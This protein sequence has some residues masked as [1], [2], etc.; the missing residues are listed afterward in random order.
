MSML[1]RYISSPKLRQIDRVEVAST[2]AEAWEAVRHLDAYRFWFVRGLFAL[3]ALPERMLSTITGGPPPLDYHGTLDDLRRPESEFQ[4]LEEQPPRG[5]VAGA[6]GTFWTPKIEWRE[7]EPATFASFDEPGYGKVAWAI[8]VAPREGGGSW[9]SFEVRVTTTDAAS[10]VAFRRYWH[11]IGLFSHA[12]RRAILGLFESELGTAPPISQRT[13]P[14]DAILAH[15]KTVRDHSIRIEA[16]PSAVWPWLVQMGCNR[17]GWY[18]IDR[19][20]NGGRPSADRIH[21]E[22]QTL[23]VGDLLDATPGGEGAFGVL[24][25]D[26]GHALVLG[27]PSLRTCGPIA[28]PEPN[29]RSTWA[30]VLEPIGDDATLLINRLRAEYRPTLAFY[31]RHGWLLA[32]HEIMQRAQLANLRTRIERVRQHREQMVAH[33]FGDASGGERPVARL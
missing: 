26:P 19:L 21:P 9:I 15:P 12:M 20:D 11:V 17:G 18:A 23:A 2:P 7:A 27:S 33:D 29:F 1:D 24:A 8:E 16:P 30:F 32:V 31:A 22:W 5:L 25:I 4:I 3:R 13:L 10:E 6:I 14:G 28:P